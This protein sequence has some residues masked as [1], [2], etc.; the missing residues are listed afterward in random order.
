LQSDCVSLEHPRG[1]KVS[2]LRRA[3]RNEFLYQVVFGLA[4]RFKPVIWLLKIA[5]MLHHSLRPGIIVS[6]KAHLVFHSHS[7]FIN[8]LAMHK[9]E[10]SFPWQ[11]LVF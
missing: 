11:E 5:V 6:A 7:H 3:N 2:I 10:N 9:W 1:V 8:L 4:E